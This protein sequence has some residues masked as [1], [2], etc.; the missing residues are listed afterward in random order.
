MC[1][2]INT[3][4]N[5]NNNNNNNVNT[6]TSN[7]ISNTEAAATADP[8][9]SMEIG[10]WRETINNVDQTGTSVEFSG[11]GDS[12]QTQ[13]VFAL[14]CLASLLALLGWL[15]QW[16][17]NWLEG[18]EVLKTEECW[19]AWTFIGHKFLFLTGWFRFYFTLWMICANNWQIDQHSTLNNWTRPGEENLRTLHSFDL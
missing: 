8:Y 16:P 1:S 11:N 18:N 14:H 6:A 12:R 7:T 15:N 17:I 5:N 3:N 2:L 13:P 4:N 19:I 10:N 9:I